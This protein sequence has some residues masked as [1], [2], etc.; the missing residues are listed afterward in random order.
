MID[1]LIALGYPGNLRPAVDDEAENAGKSV[2]RV[3]YL[4]LVEA[5]G[6]LGRDERHGVG[7][8]ETPPDGCSIEHHLRSFLKIAAGDRHLPCPGRL[9]M[10][11]WYRAKGQPPQVSRGGH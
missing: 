9:C 2:I 6:H 1:R 11:R 7:G 3:S 8:G 4:D 10:H 5:I